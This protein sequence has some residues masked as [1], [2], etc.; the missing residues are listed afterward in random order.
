M[1]MVQIIY[2]H[3]QIATQ[4]CGV[5]VTKII[6]SLVLELELSMEARAPDP[7]LVSH[8]HLTHDSRVGEKL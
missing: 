4:S 5:E 2:P 6:D 1:V 7:E 3:K 8:E